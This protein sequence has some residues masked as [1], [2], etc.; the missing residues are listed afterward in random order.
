MRKLHNFT[1]DITITTPKR[2]TS[3]ENGS[4]NGIIDWTFGVRVPFDR[5]SKFVS[6]TECG[7]S[8]DCHFLLKRVT[9]VSHTVTR[10]YPSFVSFRVT[11]T[12][13]ER[14]KWHRPHILNG[15]KGPF[16]SLKVSLSLLFVAT[17]SCLHVLPRFIGIYCSPKIKRKNLFAWVV[18]IIDTLNSWLSPVKV[19]VCVL[20]FYVIKK[21][22]LKKSF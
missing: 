11:G 3:I 14:G 8:S 18:V 5:K 17:E 19:S 15:T 1:Q 6:S 22:Q 9:I 7:G 10:L 20:H 16:E 13:R 4:Y 12:R 21:K 2:M